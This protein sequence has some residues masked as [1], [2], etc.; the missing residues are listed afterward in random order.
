GFRPTASTSDRAAFTVDIEIQMSSTANVPGALS[1]T[2]ANN[3]GSDMVVA[4]PRQSVNVPAMPANR[5][6]SQFARFPFAQPFVFG[7]NGNT[8][9]N[10]DVF[11]HGRSA[12]ASWSTD[13]AFASSSGRATTAGIG[14]GTA[15]VG[16]SSTRVTGNSYAGGETISITISGATPTNPALLIPSID[17]S[18]FV[19]GVPLPLDLSVYGAGTGCEMLVNSFLGSLPTVTDGAGSARID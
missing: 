14:C 7:T 16:S 18:E 13:R 5:P 12:G 2:F 11:L 1:S 8:N 9:I 3:V 4:L 10:V 15:T 6:T 17:M 19:P